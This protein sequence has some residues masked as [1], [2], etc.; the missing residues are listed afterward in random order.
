M[1]PR[2]KAKPCPSCG[3]PVRPDAAT[4]W[5]CG[6]V[7]NT[8]PCPACSSPLQKG[9]TTCWFCGAE[10]KASQLFSSSPAQ[11]IPPD[12]APSEAIQ[13]TPRPPVPREEPPVLEV[14]G[15]KSCP[16]CKEE[17]PLSALKCKYCGTVLGNRVSSNW[18]RSVGG[19][20]HHEHR[21]NTIR[22]LGLL[23]FFACFV[24]YCRSIADPLRERFT[25]F[26]IVILGFTLFTLLGPFVLIMAIRDLRAMGEG[27]MDSSGYG[28]TLAGL[29]LAILPTL[30]TVLGL[31]SL[32]LYV[33]AHLAKP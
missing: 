5:S 2:P 3:K 29:L 7:F 13:T 19:H 1:P 22:A 16:A 6:E 11:Q 15:V 23:S 12:P 30:A 20:I 9:S 27:R 8:V 21:G 32:A 33:L 28:Q 14:A 18:G 17:I 24:F 25:I 31:G 26:Y 10:F 4:C